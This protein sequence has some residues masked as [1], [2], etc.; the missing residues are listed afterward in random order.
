MDETRMHMMDL[1]RKGYYC[2]QIL[3]LMGLEAQGKNN[4]DLIRAVGGLA[5]GGGR[6][7]GVCGSLTGAACLIALYAAKGRDDEEEHEDLLLMLS[8]LEEWFQAEIG[9]R[10][11]GVRCNDILGNG[12]P[13][14]ERCGPI[15]AEAYM[16][17]MSIL[18]EHG[19]D[20]TESR[21]V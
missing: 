18:M 6:G 3:L 16:Q 7:E 2:S 8:E 11:G 17:A 20:P 9:G 19:L 15:V 4:P 14:T 13:S 5:L 12:T 21:E 10:Y 1:S